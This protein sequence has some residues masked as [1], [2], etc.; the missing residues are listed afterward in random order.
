MPFINEIPYAS[1]VIQFIDNCIILIKNQIG[2]S[3]SN[4]SNQTGKTNKGGNRQ[5]SDME[6]KS[7][8]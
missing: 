1:E 8:V 2:Y 7:M 5:M 3:S 6:A 4:N